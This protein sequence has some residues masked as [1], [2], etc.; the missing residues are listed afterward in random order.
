MLKVLI[1]DDHP[2]IR[3]GIKYLLKDHF[4][5]CVV[6][7]A[8]N[9]DQIIDQ[10]KLDPPTL[11][12]MDLN[13]PDTDPQRILQT[14]LA[15]RP[16]MKILIFSQNKEEIFGM[17][18]LQMGAKGYLRKG[19]DQ[20][21]F[22]TAVKTVLA[23][24]VYVNMDMNAFYLN[25]NE[26]LNPFAVL[27]KKELEVLRHLSKGEPIVNIRKIMN[28]SSS[29]VGTHK[30]KIFEKLNVNNVFELKSLLDT[31]SLG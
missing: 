30:A 4:E 20:Q 15:L 7:E 25:Q 10:V 17:M 12:M 21:E 11:I 27:T 19:G 24:N 9:G 29:T 23:G 13:M 26:Q 5:D 18:Y 1:A 16:E 8:A 22:V 28:I 31:F 2:I 3:T 14:I 6:F